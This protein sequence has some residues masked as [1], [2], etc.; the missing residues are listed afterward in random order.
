MDATSIYFENGQEMSTERSFMHR[1]KPE[2]NLR[3]EEYWDRMQH[4]FSCAIGSS[5]LDQKNKV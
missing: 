1:W 4:K 2:Y 5:A 3:R